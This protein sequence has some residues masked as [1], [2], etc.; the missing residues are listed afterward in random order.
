GIRG[1][2]VTGV[3]TCALPI[4][5]PHRRPDPAGKTPGQRHGPLGALQ[6]GAAG[7][8]PLNPSS[9]SPGQDRRL[10]PLESGIRQVEVHVDP[11][12]ERSLH[13]T[14]LPGGSSSWTVTNPNRPSGPEAAR[15]MP[16]E[17][18]PRSR[19]GFRL[20]TTT[21]WRPTSSSGL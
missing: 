12:P 7:D 5:E 20:A 6:I 3:Q 4:L 1:F 18:S 9:P 13:R 10:L 17:S 11:A 2:H 21:T 14:R 8:H 16:W 19:A 15:I